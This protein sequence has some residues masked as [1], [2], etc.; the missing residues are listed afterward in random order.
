[1]RSRLDLDKYSEISTKSRRIWRNIGQISID[2]TRFR[3]PVAN[4]KP[5]DMHPK[6]TRPNPTDWKL[7]TSWL[8]VR[9]SP[10]RVYRVD[11]RLGTNPTRADLWTPLTEADNI[12]KSFC[13]VWSVLDFVFNELCVRL[14]SE[15]EVSYGVVMKASTSDKVSKMKP[16]VGKLNS[17]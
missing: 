14:T 10:T 17:G 13:S 11:S 1:M 7:H 2:P 9:I 8:Q 12:I 6:P 5:T 3:P 16:R 4:L 15:R